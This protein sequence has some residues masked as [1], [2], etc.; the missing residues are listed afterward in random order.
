MKKIFIFFLSAVSVIVHA[1]VNLVPNPSFEQYSSCPGAFGEVYKATGWNSFNSAEYFH[2]CATSS[3]VQVPTN[4][5]GYQYPATGNA[6]SGFFAYFASVDYHE[7][8]YTQLLNPL[9]TNQKYFISFKVSPADSGFCVYS[10][11]TGIKFFTTQP[12]SILLNNTAHFFTNTIITDTAGWTTVT[13]SFIA[14]SAYNYAVIGNFFSDANTDIIDNNCNS[15]VSYY[16]IDD[17]CVS[18]DSLSCNALLPV[19]L[20]SFLAKAVNNVVQLYWRTAQEN[21]NKG[22]EIFR[23]ESNAN[24]FQKIGFIAGAGYSSIERGYRFNDKN[25]RNNT[26][27][28]YKL[29]QID[30]DNRY[31]Y[32][33]IQKAKVYYKGDGGFFVNPN[34]V[35]NELKIYFAESVQEACRVKITDNSGKV[36]LTKTFFGMPAGHSLNISMQNFASGLYFVE[37]FK[38]SQIS[39]QKIIKK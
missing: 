26:E 36:V 37:L 18:T 13:G 17:I 14:D 30:F 7:F 4:Y 12:D 16:Y 22:F 32:S 2:S 3:D 1:Q 27:Y 31:S 39:T 10:N 9:I 20:L 38:N 15:P 28:F 21:N 5:M 23:S 6:Y 24:N 19:N 25:V 35:E 8:L 29:K 11:K 33:S 34:P